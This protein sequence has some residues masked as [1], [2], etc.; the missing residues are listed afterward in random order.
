MTETE[1]FL[2]YERKALN[3]SLDHDH[4]DV[5]VNSE[6]HDEEELDSQDLLLPW[7][8][9]ITEYLKEQKDLEDQLEEP[10][11]LAN[12]I[13]GRLLAKSQVNIGH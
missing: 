2:D 1:Y 10:E 5:D 11:A 12:T 6:D 13:R 7:S 8:C 4:I 9:C 3:N